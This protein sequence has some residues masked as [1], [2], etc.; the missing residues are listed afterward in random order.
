MRQKWDEILSPTAFVSLTVNSMA[1]GMK[2]QKDEKDRSVI[3]LLDPFRAFGMSCCHVHT[4]V[5]VLEPVIENIVE[6]RLSRFF[7]RQRIVIGL[8][9]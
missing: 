3:R 5:A 6:S 1:K 9:H 4:I 8:A 2:N 7:T